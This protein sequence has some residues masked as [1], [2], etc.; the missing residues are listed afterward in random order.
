MN[1]E[2]FHVSV[3]IPVFNGEAFLAE[4]VESI[5]LQNYKHLEIIIVDD[6]STDRTAKI[7]ADFQSNVRY[8]YQSNSGPAVARNRGI[9]MS[10]GN[11]ISFLDVDDLWSEDKLRIQLEYLS[12][13]GTVEIVIGQ[14]Q[15]M[16]LIGVENDKFQFKNW[17]EPEM[18]MHLGSALFRKTVFDRVG[19]LDES[20]SY[21]EDCDLFMRAKEMKIPILVHKE[22]TY[23]YRRHEQNMTNDMKAGFNSALM[24]LKQSLDRRRLQGNGEVK[25]LPRFSDLMTDSS[26]AS[27]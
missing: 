23:F 18:S 14:I 16:Q 24:M 21:C 5:Q 13:N 27:A 9:R 12:R 4:A 19:Y 6:G 1:S 7:A 11:I 26:Q 3:I 22:V 25:E 15:R 10:R 20:L 2:Q 17:S 8:F